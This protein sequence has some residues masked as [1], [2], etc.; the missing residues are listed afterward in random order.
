MSENKTQ[1]ENEK[2][3]RIAGSITVDELAQALG[4]T[5]HLR[6]PLV[7]FRVEHLPLQIREADHV[8]VHQDQRAYAG[9]GQIEGDG[10]SQPPDSYD[11]YTGA[12][13]T[14]LSFRPNLG[15]G[16]L[17]FISIVYVHYYILKL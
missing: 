8:I 1:A 17:A 5:E 2:V 12:R 4:G 14:L 7:G 13:Q 6:F 10:A 9:C 11:E 3:I 16:R 15:E